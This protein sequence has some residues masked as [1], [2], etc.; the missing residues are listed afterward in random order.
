MF[1]EREAQRFKAWY[2]ED[3]G[4]CWEWLGSKTATGYGHFWY[5]SRDVVAHRI[6]Y[7]WLNGPIP[8]GLE[9]DHL[10]RNRSCVN[11]AHLEAVTHQENCRRGS[12]ATKTH[13]AQGH[14]YTEA[15][16]WLN[17]NHRYC[18]TCRRE[19]QRLKEP[20]RN[21]HIYE[22]VCQGCGTTF[23][24]T[25]HQVY[26]AQ[27]CGHSVAWAKRRTRH[28][29]LNSSLQSVPRADTAA[30]VVVHEV[31]DNLPAVRLEG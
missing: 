1:T 22:R 29:G 20:T 9:I 2:V 12:Q 21:R 26:C 7:E 18:R 13:C 10:C 31:R 30:A 6:A 4:K 23:M 14:P 5:Q 28:G 24:A 25:L 8:D 27:A 15:N 17:R 19:R 16:T 11:P 3:P